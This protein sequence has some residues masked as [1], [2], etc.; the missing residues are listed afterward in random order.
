MGRISRRQAAPPGWLVPRHPRSRRDGRQGS[1]A[2]R[3]GREPLPRRYSLAAR[4]APGHLCVAS[5][6]RFTSA[7]RE[8]VF[9]CFARLARISNG[10]LY[11]LG[12]E[13]SATCQILV[14]HRMPYR[15][16]VADVRRCNSLIIDPSLMH[17]P[18]GPPATWVAGVSI[19]V[20]GES[21]HRGHPPAR[22]RRQYGSRPQSEALDRRSISSTVRPLLIAPALEQRRNAIRWRGAFREA[23]ECSSTAIRL[24]ARGA[25]GSSGPCPVSL[26]SWTQ[27]FAAQGGRTG[28]QGRRT[29]FPRRTGFGRHVTAPN[30]RLWRFDDG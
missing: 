22:G 19:Q 3:H 23:T 16:G 29:G 15:F 5:G 12:R 25:G 30:W 10:H 28:E 9:G 8:P 13:P 21:R 26:S 27:L 4:R 2:S 14:G 20:H 18:P 6:R 17:P 24:V 7:A 11:N 1:D